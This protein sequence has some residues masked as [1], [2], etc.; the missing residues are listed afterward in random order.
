MSLAG[1]LSS[2]L[3][4]AAASSAARCAFCAPFLAFASAFFAAFFEGA[5]AP[6]SLDSILGTVAGGVRWCKCA[7]ELDQ[8]R[9]WRGRRPPLTHPPTFLSNEPP[10]ADSCHQLPDPGL[11]DWQETIITTT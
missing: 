3:A 1:S 6:C 10:A 5:A 7:G 11:S 4:T 9:V 8:K 2:T